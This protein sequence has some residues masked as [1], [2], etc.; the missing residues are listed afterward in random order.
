MKFKY[1]FA[2]AAL[3]GLFFVGCGEDDKPAAGNNTDPNNTNN[4]TTV[5]PNNTNNETTPNTNNNTTVE[6]NNTTGPEPIPAPPKCGDEDE[7][8]RCQESAEGF[9]WETASII[10]TFAIVEDN[11]CCFDFTG[12]GQPDNALGGLLG[13]APDINTSIQEG[14]DTG[15][16]ALVLEHAGLSSLESGDFVINFWLGEWD[17][18]D[19]LAETGGNTVL[20]D[21]VSIDQGAQPQAY[22][23][24]AALADGTVTAGP[25]TI[26]ISIDLLGTPLSIR[27]SGAQIEADAGA[28]SDLETGVQLDNGIIG[29]YVTGADLAGAVNAYVKGSC[30]CLGLGQTNLMTWNQAEGD[31][32]CAAVPDE[33]GGN[34]CASDDTCNTIAGSCNIIF[35]LVAPD[36]DTDGDSVPDAVSIG[37]EFT[38][39]GA[40]ITGVAAAE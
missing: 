33:E 10:N 14:I 3:A 30:E 15:A 12:D 22:V 39:V 6:P 1:G 16:V 13:I 34:T 27:I 29:G 9:E 17:G 35:G 38:A 20:I 4:N 18:I 23:P 2:V 32:D 19:A 5:D 37:A 7:P 25:G 24:G 21:P 36:V 28:N 11:S 31:A 26:S 8:A 40:Q